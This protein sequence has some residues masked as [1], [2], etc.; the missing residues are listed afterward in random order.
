MEKREL[1]IT[2]PEGYEIDERNSTFKKIVFRQKVQNVVTGF[3]P[4][5]LSEDYDINKDWAFSIFTK[6]S[7]GAEFE[8]SVK[9]GHESSLF[10][11]TGSGKWYD[12]NGHPVEGYLYYKPR[13]Q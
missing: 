1:E 3:S 13:R 12:E 9:S 2:P 5:N 10:I 11:A 6:E 8:G 4:A 7:Q